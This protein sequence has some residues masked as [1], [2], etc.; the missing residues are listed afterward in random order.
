M[1]PASR[2]P[3]A[4][5][6]IVLIAAIDAFAG[7]RL[8]LSILYLAPIAFAAWTTGRRNGLLVAGAA[9]IARIGAD[10]RWSGLDPVTAWNALAWT[11]AFVAVARGASWTRARQEEVRALEARVDELVQIEHSFARTDP[12]TSLI[13]RRAFIDALQRAEARGRRHGSSLAVVRLDLDNFGRLNQ[14]YSRQEGDQLLR[15]V[16]TSL[17]LT[18]RMGDLAARL[19]R[20]EFALLLYACGPDDAS[21][22]GQRIVEEVAELGRA[23]EH[24]RITAS[25]GI[26]C[27]AAP[28]PDPDEMMRLAGAALHRARQAGGNTAMIERE[29]TPD[30]LRELRPVSQRPDALRPH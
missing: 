16:A 13:N 29:W 30:Q 11:A 20:D 4:I 26:A 19:E 8:P 27:F 14:A 12:L 10:V 22:V 7:P 17:S 25:V 3:A 5:A 2:L 28:G 23:F 18:T 21:R 24:S 6:A 9:A 15:T 1:P